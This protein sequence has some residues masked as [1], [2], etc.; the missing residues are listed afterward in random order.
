MDG[1]A[2]DGGPWYIERFAR[3]LADLAPPT[4]QAYLDDVH[5]FNEWCVDHGCVEPSAFSRVLVRAWLA[6]VTR[7]GLA[8]ST[9]SR[10]LAAVRK[11]C[12]FL[13]SAG[14]LVVDPT[15]R[16]KGPAKASR[17]PRVLSQGE[18]TDLLDRP[19][20]RPHDG[21]SD[22]VEL[23]SQQD[24][25]VLE[26]LYGSGL[27][28]AE[29]C[30]L[31]ERSWDRRRNMLTVR[32]KG[33]KER[34][35]P[36]GEPAAVALRLWL[37]V[38]RARLAPTSPTL[39]VNQRTRPLTPR[40]VRR[41]LDRRSA[42]PTH[43]HALRHTYATHLLDGGADLRVVQELLGHADL[44]TTQRYTHVSK[45]RLRSVHQGTHPRAGSV[46]PGQSG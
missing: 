3:S 30:S 2:V 15:D 42:R 39:F 31:D 10:R 45:E 34:V 43:P 11:Y 5:R 33:D 20:V 29:L 21:E 8:P 46:R 28:V 4:R 6:D 38:G 19:P 40:D 18:V 14:V 22:L 17:L 26:L 41:I 35:V 7:R 16:L 25:A 32:G 23:W 36:V 27:R 44:S 13:R 24:Q 12:G 1:S 9:V 37:E